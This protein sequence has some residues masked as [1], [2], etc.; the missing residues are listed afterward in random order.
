MKKLSKT[1]EQIL[2]Y[3]ATHGGITQA[4]AFLHLGVGRLGA[5]IYDMRE[6]G[7]PIEARM[8]GVKKKDG[9]QAF[10]AK[11]YIADGFDPRLEA[12]A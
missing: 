8:V 6:R 9:S 10:V 1:M 5:R 7:I 4:D 2:A 11:Y 3:M 12:D